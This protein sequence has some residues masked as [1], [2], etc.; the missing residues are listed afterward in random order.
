MSHPTGRTEG[1]VRL[2]GR[3]RLCG[4]TGSG[5]LGAAFFFYS[6][7]TVGYAI[8][9]ARTS[10][11]LEAIAGIRGGTCVTEAGSKPFQARA[12]GTG[13]RQPNPSHTHFLQLWTRAGCAGCNSTQRWSLEECNGGV[14]RVYRAD[15]V[16][17]PPR[18]AHLH[19]LASPSSASWARPCTPSATVA[20][21]REHPRSLSPRTAAAGHRAAPVA[22]LAAST[23]AP[24]ACT[25]ARWL[26]AVRSCPAR[27]RTHA[28]A[29]DC[30]R[31][32]RLELVH[33]SGHDGRLH[34]SRGG[35][36][37]VWAVAVMGGGKL[38]AP[39]RHLALL[40]EVEELGVLLLRVDVGVDQHHRERQVLPLRQVLLDVP[41]QS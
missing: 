40:E 21:A 41:G 11:R 5:S 16:I 32:V 28:H 9:E 39:P 29:I 38:L 15:R 33:L 24:P 23:W 20:T 17:M 35:R 3:P 19:L 18:R 34:L 31:L 22:L 25:R 1:Y 8:G 7:R 13:H 4:R 30:A 27:T 26:S 12:C 6:V 14:Y 36:V 2:R 37:Y 10:P